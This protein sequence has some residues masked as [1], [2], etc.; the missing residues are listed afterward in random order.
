MA[1]AGVLCGACVGCVSEGDSRNPQ[2]EER[3]EKG[4]EDGFKRVEEVQGNNKK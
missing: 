2:K 1:V 4:E 3:E